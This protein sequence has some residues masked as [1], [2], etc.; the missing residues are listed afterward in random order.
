M[1]ISLS[2]QWKAML[3]L[4]RSTR[5]ILAGDRDAATSLPTGSAVAVS[6]RSKPKR[7]LSEKLM[8]SGL[9]HREQSSLIV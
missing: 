7:L 8:A 3:L 6:T 1:L 9:I 4:R 2:G 5:S